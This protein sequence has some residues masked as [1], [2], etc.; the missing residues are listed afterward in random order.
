MKRAYQ[1]HSSKARA[2]RPAIEK[3][4]TLAKK[5]HATDDAST[6][7]LEGGNCSS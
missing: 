2:L 6:V 1:D 4:I 7:T 3:A 5:A